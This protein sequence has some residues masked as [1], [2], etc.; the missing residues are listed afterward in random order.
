MIM[1]QLVPPGNVERFRQLPAVLGAHP[2][3]GSYV[4]M[5]QLG[6]AYY[7]FHFLILLPLLGKIERPRPLPDSIS[8]PVL[9]SRAA[10]A[11]AE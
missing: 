9:A 11:P 5:A 3:E 8:K 4:L 7:F 1:D 2:P 10:A 6:T